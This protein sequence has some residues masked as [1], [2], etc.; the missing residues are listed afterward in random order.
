MSNILV[1]FKIGVIFSGICL[2]FGL[3]T[4]IMAGSVLSVSEPTLELTWSKIIETQYEDEPI[5]FLPTSD[6][7][8]LFIGSYFVD[9]YAQ[10]PRI[11][12]VDSEGN[13]EWNRTYSP[14]S[15]P[16][17]HIRSIVQTSDGGY[18]I[19]GFSFISFRF[20]DSW[21]LW[22]V[23]IDENGA[24]LWNRTF[25]GL[26][27]SVDYGSQI[28]IAP[29]GGFLISGATQSLSALPSDYWNTDYWLIKTDANGIEKWNKTYHRI[30][31][32]QGT[33]LVP[34]QDGNYLLSG[35]SRQSNSTNSPF[36]IWVIKIDENGTILW[37]KAFSKGSEWLS[38]WE[39]ALIGTPD[40][41]FLLTCF[42]F[43]DN[44]YMGKDYWIIKCTEEGDIEWNKIFGGNYYDTPEVCLLNSV[45]DYYIGGSYNSTSG[46]YESGDFCL[47]KLS[48]SGE[49]LWQL[50]E[51]EVT[52]GERI[53]DMILTEGPDSKESIVALGFVE[54]GYDAIESAA[55]RDCWLGKFE[56][57]TTI[58]TTSTNQT[59]DFIGLLGLCL[60][61]VVIIRFRKKAY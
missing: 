50:I 43:G 33:A 57:T 14:P 12:K 46:N 44:W 42:P 8:Y 27:Q 45:G 2:F 4:P 19:A 55:N 52:V 1:N 48:S 35:L 24:E 25:N 51:G 3:M 6:G 17:G 21:D 20:Y 38:S 15:K 28:Q 37:D 11:F 34:L 31:S 16:Q 10:T 49:L 32:D 26:K 60:G 29:D 36:S 22:V 23:K 47:I 13:E 9:G 7:G 41:G 61:L 53:V 59:S 5:Q 18:A 39:R 54:S 58:T 56:T 30:G 40:G